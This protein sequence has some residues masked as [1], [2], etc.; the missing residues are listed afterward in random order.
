MLVDRF[1]GLEESSDCENLP[2]LAEG[3]R[4]A[5]HRARIEYDLEC[6]KSEPALHNMLFLTPERANSELAIRTMGHRQLAT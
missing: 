3:L 1:R 2:C 4:W 5:K 6:I